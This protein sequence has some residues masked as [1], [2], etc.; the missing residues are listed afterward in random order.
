MNPYIP[1]TIPATLLAP[2][3]PY[4]LLTILNTIRHPLVTYLKLSAS[5]QTISVPFRVALSLKQVHKQSIL[6]LKWAQYS[7]SYQ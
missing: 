3:Y 7:K 6:A 2:Q 5:S 1:S 4:L